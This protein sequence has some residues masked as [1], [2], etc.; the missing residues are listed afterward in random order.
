[1]PSTFTKGMRSS[2]DPTWETPPE[3][4]AAFNRIFGF[5]LDAA[6]SDQNHLCDRYYTLEDDALTRSWAPGPAWLNPPY[7]DVVGPFMRK[8]ADEA[9][10]GVTTV[11]LVAARIE[12]G[13]FQHNLG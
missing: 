11:A 8:A 5:T 10:L 4:F 12:T 13:W 3:V 6:A 2:E 9:R 1:M 7:G